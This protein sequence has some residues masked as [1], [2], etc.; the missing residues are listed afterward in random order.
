MIKD[1]L[2]AG[3]LTQQIWQEFVNVSNNLFKD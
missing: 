1:I 2:P 3:K